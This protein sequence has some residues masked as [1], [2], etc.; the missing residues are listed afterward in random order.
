VQKYFVF[1]MVE[2]NDM[3]KYLYIYNDPNFCTVLPR[4]GGST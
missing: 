4:T 2:S 3:K 1:E